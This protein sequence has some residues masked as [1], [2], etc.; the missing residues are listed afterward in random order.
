MRP[1]FVKA[2]AIAALYGICAAIW[3]MGPDIFLDDDVGAER[4]ELFLDAAFVLASTLLLFLTLAHGA[5]RHAT[6]HSRASLPRATPPGAWR[7]LFA[8][9]PCSR[10]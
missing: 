2:G 10:P 8:P 5:K 3:I 4:I 6:R 1:E 9:W 7:S